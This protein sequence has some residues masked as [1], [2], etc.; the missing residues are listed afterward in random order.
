M[1]NELLT[2]ASLLL[3]SANAVAQTT[4][5]DAE[6]SRLIGREVTITEPETD[7]H[8]F[9]PKGPASVC[10][11]GPP[12]RQCYTAP[13]DFGG[14]PAV[15]VVQIAKD[16]PALLFIAASGGVSGFSIHFALLRPG[17]GKDLEN[18]FAEKIPASNQSQHAF[19]NDSSISEA[20]IFL[21]ADFKWGP[22]ES[23]YSP[24]RYIVSSYV[25]GPV[26]LGDLPE[27]FLE[28]EFMTVRKYDLEDGADILASEKE[29]I[30]ARLRRVK[31]AEPRREEPR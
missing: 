31:A 2:L 9:F 6:A 1:R 18:L 10:L 14:A 27:C 21:V 3:A 29:E 30:L 8:G 16:V 28:D 5:R 20:P 12:Q 4:R 22:F 23:H 24:H 17:A 25:L 15:S 7:A 11:E 26:E 19:W 13:E